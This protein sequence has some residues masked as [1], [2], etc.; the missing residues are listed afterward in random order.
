MRNYNLKFLKIKAQNFEKLNLEC[1]D[2]ITLIFGN[3]SFNA[4]KLK[5]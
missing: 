5:L 4:V 1:L 2:I 3:C